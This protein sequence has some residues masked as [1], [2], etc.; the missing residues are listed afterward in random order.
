LTVEASWQ[1]VPILQD[2]QMVV[3]LFWLEI[4]NNVVYV[5]HNRFKQLLITLYFTLVMVLTNIGILWFVT[6]LS[7][8]IFIFV[9]MESF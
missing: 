8:K 2:Y 5:K 9:D 4:L 1:Q 3:I 6:I 7:G